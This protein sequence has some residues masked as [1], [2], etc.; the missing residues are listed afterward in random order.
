MKEKQLA[1]SV[2]V[3]GSKLTHGFLEP[4][5]LILPGNEYQIDGYAGQY[6]EYAIARLHGTGVH[7]H[8][9]NEYCGNQIYNGEYQGHAN[10]AWQIGL[11]PAQPGQAENRNA[12]AQLYGKSN[13]G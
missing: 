1:N 6:H 11:S 8:N 4:N 3:H 2:S 10:G 5:R 12:N 7:G 9:S 13:V